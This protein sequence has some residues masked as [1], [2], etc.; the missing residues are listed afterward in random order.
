MDAV[1]VVVCIWLATFRLTRLLIK[2]KIIEPWRDRAQIRFE[3]AWL[4]KD[5][6]GR[7]PDPDKWLSPGA[8]FLT[9]PWCVSTWVGAAVTGAT[10][11]L[12]RFPVPIL[13]AIAASGVTGLLATVEG[14]LG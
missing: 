14:A 3:S 8:Y 13:V 7:K 6:A 9:C 10:W 1:L 5:P 12:H 11:P 4:A 2:D